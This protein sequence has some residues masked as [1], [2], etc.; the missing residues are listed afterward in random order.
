[1]VCLID[2]DRIEE[3][4]DL[5]FSLSFFNDGTRTVKQQ[6][7]LNTP[8]TLPYTTPCLKTINPFASFVD[9]MCNNP[10]V[11]DDMMT[12]DDFDSGLLPKSEYYSMV[13]DNEGSISPA[14]LHFSDILWEEGSMKDVE[15]D[16]SSFNELKTEDNTTS[17][18][19]IRSPHHK[20]ARLHSTLTEQPAPAGHLL[21]LQKLDIKSMPFGKNLLRM[22]EGVDLDTSHKY[23]GGKNNTQHY[24][25]VQTIEL[26]WSSL[27]QAYHDTATH[28]LTCRASILGYDKQSRCMTVL[29]RLSCDK[30]FVHDQKQNRWF[31]KFDDILVQFA[32]HNY[33]QRLCLK[34]ELIDQGQITLADIQSKEFQTITKRGLEKEMQR[35]YASKAAKDKN[36][37][38]G[39]HVEKIEPPVGAI[40]GGQLVKL[41]LTTGNAILQQYI[42]AGTLMVLFGGK[43][44]T[45]HC[46]KKNEIICETPQQ[47][48]PGVVDVT[49]LIKKKGQDEVIANQ[50]QFHY[51]DPKHPDTPGI[52]LSHFFSNIKL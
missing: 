51:L 5:D 18:E 23:L 42:D 52:V 14:D 36:R 26:N 22:V 15:E 25:P 11:M 6:I 39:I 12:Q 19:Y 20:R 10:L 47:M 40:S 33:G 37:L 21:K 1:M 28:H 9:S 34:F 16:F 29:G 27:P 30:P 49:I 17:Q 24:M 41:I 13:D 38:G 8:T 46:V 4:T 35:G 7:S 50:I 31:A 44:S 45:V 2:N 32:S 43:G 3:W 48:T